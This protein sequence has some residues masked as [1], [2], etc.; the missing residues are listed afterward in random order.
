MNAQGIRLQKAMAQAGIAS[1]RHAE[2]MIQAGLVRVNGRVVTEPGVSIVAGKDLLEVEGRPVHWGQPGIREVWAL[3]KPKRCVTSLS[4]P[5]G[6]ST[7]KDYLPHTSS[8]LFPIG[9]L[10]YDAEGLLLLTNDGDLAHRVAHPSFSVSKTYLVK[11]KGLLDRQ[12]LKKLKAGPVL[13]GKRRR[14]VGARILHTLIDKTWVEVK[15]KEGI[16]HHIKKM[17]ADCGFP[18]LKIKRYQIGPIALEDMEPGQTRRLNNGEVGRLL[19]GQTD[20]RRKTG[21][22]ARSGKA[23]SPPRDGNILSS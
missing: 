15:L 1:R 9:R 12:T 11:V 2:R 18:V 16:Q 21:K 4:D 3:Y 19:S 10:D 14:P 17:F 6:R 8:R 7:I 22:T 20:I 13:E 5:Q 23:T